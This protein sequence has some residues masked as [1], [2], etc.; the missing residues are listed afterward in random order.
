TMDY[1]RLGLG[2]RVE[3][4]NARPSPEGGAVA[5]WMKLRNRDDQIPAAGI[6]DGVLA[7][8]A[9]V[10][11]FRLHPERSLLCFDEPELYLHPRLLLRVLGFFEAIAESCPVILATHSDRLLDGLRDP[12]RSVVLCELDD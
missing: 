5:L 3:S 7:F 12:A 2:D 6:A 4:V 8:L 9:F 1:V 10:A 11:M